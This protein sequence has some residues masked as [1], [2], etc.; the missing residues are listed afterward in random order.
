M[1]GSDF[2]TL[3]AAIAALTTQVAAT[4]GTEGSA[5]A[6]I[7]GFSAQVQTAVAAALAADDAADQGS[8]Q[9]ANQAIT[10][11]TARFNASAAALGAAVA[12]NPG[13]TPPASARR[14]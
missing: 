6:L 5:V 9:A 10:D 4:E 11:V 1:A 12:A 8:I 13:P 14:T 2:S 3:N 7:N